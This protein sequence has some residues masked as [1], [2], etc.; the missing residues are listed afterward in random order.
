MVIC[1]RFCI[2]NDE[3]K[4]RR[5]IFNN[6][7]DMGRNKPFLRR[8]QMITEIVTDTTILSI[9]SKPCYFNKLEVLNNKEIIQNMIDTA[10]N[11][12]PECIGLAANQI[13]VFKRIILMKLD[14]EWTA[15]LNPFFTPVKSAGM[16]KYKEGCL[17]YPDRLHRP[18]IR[19]YKK[20]NLTYQTVTGQKI[21]ITFIKINAVIVQHEIDHL[22]GKLI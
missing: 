10:K 4:P 5:P 2:Y 14:Q 21:K 1:S 8:S 13:N 20:L 17:S 11:N 18:K 7:I 3:R 19:R 16:K 6:S 22:N 12:E 9:K 15:M